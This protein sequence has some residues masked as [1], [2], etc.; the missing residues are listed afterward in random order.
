MRRGE[1]GGRERKKIDNRATLQFIAVVSV[2]YPGIRKQ[3]IYSFVS[4]LDL[5]RAPLRCW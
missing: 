4:F 2:Q 1:V 5:I 3:P